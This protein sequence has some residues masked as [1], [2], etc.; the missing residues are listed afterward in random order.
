LILEHWKTKSL[1]ALAISATALSASAAPLRYGVTEMGDFNPTGVNNLGQVSGWVNNGDSQKAVVYSGGELSMVGRLSGVSHAYGLNDSGK[2]VGSYGSDRTYAFSYA[3]NTVDH[4]NPSASSANAVNNAGQVAGG[5]DINGTTHAYVYDNKKLT[6]INTGGSG[7][8]SV[9]T[10]LSDT[11]I[12]VGSRWDDEFSERHAFIRAN[13]VTTDLSG[14]VGGY[15]SANGVN[16]SGQVILTVG[17]DAGSR[18]SYI[19][20]N[21]AATNLGGQAAGSVVAS[22]I[23]NAGAVVG[24]AAFFDAPFTTSAFLWQNGSMINLNTLIDPTLGWTIVNAFDINEHNQIAVLGCQWNGDCQA[25]LLSTVPEADTY[26]MLF[27]GL[28]MMTWALRRRKPA[29]A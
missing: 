11:G 24:S 1:L 19:Y 5:L 28:G 10:A 13:G 6:D 14:A 3:A 4:I 7:S 12:V 23:N 21:G 26:A 16:D 25:L 2:I 22:A 8:G 15:S 20:G 17:G 27:A 18:A 29:T 9:A